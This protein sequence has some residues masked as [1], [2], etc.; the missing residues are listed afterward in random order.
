MPSLGGSVSDP[1]LE[2]V[3]A[4]GK[5]L[6]LLADP[7]TPAEIAGKVAGDL[8]EASGDHGEHSRRW[9]VSTHVQVLPGVSDGYDDLVAVARRCIEQERWDGLLCLTDNPLRDGQYALVAEFLRDH[10][11][12]LLSLPA[13]GALPLRR[14]VGAVAAELT[15]ELTEPPEHHQSKEGEQR[16]QGTA[17]RTGRFS[18]VEAPDPQVTIRIMASRAPL[19]L[20]VGLVRANQPWRLL[21]GLKGALAAAL[22]TSAYVLI[23]SS[24]W[25]FAD[26][27]ST[28]KL[29]LLMLFS[30]ASMVT[31]L[32]VDHR[33]WERPSRDSERRRIRL[34]N[35]STVVTLL[36]GIACAYAVLYAVN[37]IGET[38]LID[39]GFLET[40]LGHPARITDYLSIAWFA[41]SVS[42]LVGAVGSGFE[43]EESVRKA[44]Y[45]RRERE[46]HEQAEKDPDHRATQTR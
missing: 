27:I 23:N 8:A 15:Q 32:V 24:T 4:D 35:A 11:V 40:T 19:R 7:G 29:T 43:D 18:R 5:V 39:P 1:T 36:I 33:L 41:T 12:A 17:T 21:G 34:F 22:A 42:L 3:S 30:I 16:Q 38:F 37:L 44:A 31:W 45:S 28:L 26:Q 46:R 9:E 20:L 10:R 6:G 13:F 25:Q 14:H 2:S